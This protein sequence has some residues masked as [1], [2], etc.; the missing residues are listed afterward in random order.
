MVP[1][2]TSRLITA[3]L[4]TTSSW[5]RGCATEAPRPASQEANRPMKHINMI[6]LIAVLGFVLAS[7]LRSPALGQVAVRAKKDAICSFVDE[8]L[9]CDLVR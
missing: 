4:E 3:A 1:V 7:P 5:K 9:P 8:I 6:L 2:M